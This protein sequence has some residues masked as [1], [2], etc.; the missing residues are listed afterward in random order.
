MVGGEDNDLTGSSV[1]GYLRLRFKDES[2]RP[3]AGVEVR[4]VCG[5]VVIY[6]TP[7]YGGTNPT[8]DSEGYT[9]WIIV[10]IG[11]FRGTTLETNIITV[12]AYHEGTEITETIET[13]LETDTINK[14]I[15]IPPPPESG[16]GSLLFAYYLF[17][18][19][20]SSNSGV[21]VV[22]VGVGAL[23]A[24]A[25]LAVLLYRRRRR[26]EGRLHGPD[27]CLAPTHPK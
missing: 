19:Y 12:T 23:A 21:V 17:Q 15:V 25:T 24:A 20:S 7:R 22:G 3:L 4:V 27:V 9:P 1:L 6:A 11:T 13:S 8:T 5:G 10:P 16:S 14:E 18:L 2:G 26:R